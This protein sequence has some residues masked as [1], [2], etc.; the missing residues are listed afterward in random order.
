MSSSKKSGAERLKESKERKR[1]QTRE[2]VQRFHEKKREQLREAKRSDSCE[3]DEN[4][5][6][7]GPFKHRSEN[8][9]AV[10]KVKQVLPV[11][12]QKKAAVVSASVESQTTRRTLTLNG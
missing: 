3:K 8:K 5:K 1:E 7:N 9:R 4:T 12:P 11:S 6:L 2:R 10:D